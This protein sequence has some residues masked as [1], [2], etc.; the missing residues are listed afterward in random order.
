[1]R[2]TVVLILAQ[3]DKAPASQGMKRISDRDFIC[4]N[5]GIM[6]P[7]PKCSVC[8]RLTLARPLHILIER[9]PRCCIPRMIDV[10]GA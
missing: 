7:L 6:S 10:S 8:N 9:G 5:H 1:M 4:R 2:G 3:N